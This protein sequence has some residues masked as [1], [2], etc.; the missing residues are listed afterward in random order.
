M[1]RA[2]QIV[3]PESIRALV[4]APQLIFPQYDKHF[5]EDKMAVYAEPV[6][7][8]EWREVVAQVEDIQRAIVY[9]LPQLAHPDFFFTRDGDARAHRRLQIYEHW[10]RYLNLTDIPGQ[11]DAAYALK[12]LGNTEHYARLEKQFEGIDEFA[13]FCHAIFDYLRPQNVAHP[14]YFLRS[15]CLA[16]RANWQPTVTEANLRRACVCID[17]LLDML[18]DDEAHVQEAITVL[19]LSL[20]GCLLEKGGSEALDPLNRQLQ[21][22]WL[23]RVQGDTNFDFLEKDHGFFILR[24]VQQLDG[25]WAARKMV[26]AIRAKNRE[27]LLWKPY[28]EEAITSANLQDFV[29]LFDLLPSRQLVLASIEKMNAGGMGLQGVINALM[30]PEMAQHIAQRRHYNAQFLWQDRKTRR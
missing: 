14:G 27:M 12:L 8:A 23:Q 11:R 18:Q 15:F 16:A 1:R 25:T 6:P 21:Q 3:T 24:G 5:F 9:L 4:K 20:A 17:R 22:L 28:S 19:P 10:L 13:E 7:L 26:R 2:L 30:T 29:K